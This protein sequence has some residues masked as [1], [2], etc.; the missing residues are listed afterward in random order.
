MTLLRAL[1]SYGVL[2]MAILLVNLHLCHFIFL[3]PC[4]ALKA[5]HVF[6]NNT[7]LAENKAS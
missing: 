2:T 4:I 6:A 5:V 3:K 1:L 7:F